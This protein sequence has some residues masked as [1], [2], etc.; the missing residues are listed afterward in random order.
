MK[1]FRSHLLAIGVLVSV[2]GSALAVQEELNPNIGNGVTITSNSDASGGEAFI[3]NDAGDNVINAVGGGTTAINNSNNVVLNYDSNNDEAGTFS[4]QSGG[5]NVL[6]ANNDG[7]VTI[8]NMLAT[9][10]IDNN[11]DEIINAGNISGVTSLSADTN[12]GTAGGTRL[13]VFNSGVTMRSFSD[14][15]LSTLN[16]DGFSVSHNDGT[17]TNSIEVAATQQTTIGGGTFSY[18]TTIVGGALVEGDLGV[19]GSIYALNPTASSGILVGNNGLTIDGATNTTSLVA[20][21]NNDRSDGGSELIMQ[22]SQA[23]MLVYN[24]QTGVPHGLVIT[25][26]ETVLSGGTNS[27]SLTLN[28]GGATFTNTVTGGPARVT[29]V[30]D[31]HSR[32]DAVNYGQ[33]KETYGGIASVAAMANIPDPAPGK[34]FAV[35]IGFGNFEDEQAFALGGAASL[36]ENVSLQASVGRSVDNTSF[37]AG[38]GFSW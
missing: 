7:N 19:N 5:D 1:T 16:D 38:V 11:N 37:G 21:S 15:T 24:Q 3:V 20:D 6:T 18:G 29:G 36:P 27:T 35:G 31:G 17:A 4:I 26:T 13:G 33:L 34:A 12:G 9:N 2:P 32:F 10:G 28:D 23:S 22:Q 14:S 30:A 8:V 25:Q